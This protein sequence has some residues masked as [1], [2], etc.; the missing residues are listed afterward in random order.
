MVRTEF[1]RK[2]YFTP[3]WARSGIFC[4]Y[5]KILSLIFPG[6]YLKWKII[7]LLFTKNPLFGKILVLKLLGQ[8]DCRIFWSVTYQERKDRPSWLSCIYINIRFPTRWCY[9]FCWAWPG[10]LKVLKITSLQHL[11]NISK[12]FCMKVNTTIFY[13]PIPSFLV[14]I[15]RHAQSTQNNK[16]A[17]Y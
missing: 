11:S 12:N 8:S 2:F 6:N 14:A 4:I 3:K 15:V 13:K 1:W 5:W 9:Y 10:M 17:I 16:F 7:L